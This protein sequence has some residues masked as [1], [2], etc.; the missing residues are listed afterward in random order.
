MK[1]FLFA[2]SLLLAGLTH[3]ADLL[4]PPP[5]PDIAAR[6]FL[7]MDFQSGQVL[8]SEKPDERVE[9]ASLTS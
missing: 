5:S 7:L 8:Q 3:A 2:L 1:S 6:A 4:P 9:P